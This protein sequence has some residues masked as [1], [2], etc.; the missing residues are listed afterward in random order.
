MVLTARLLWIHVF[1]GIAVWLS[2]YW[3]GLEY[4]VVALYLFVLARE[5]GSMRK[6]RPL[7]RLLISLAWQ[8]PA[9]F[10]VFTLLTGLNPMA[11]YDYAIFILGFWLTPILPC[12]ALLPPAALAH[13]LYYYGLIISPALLSLWIW[14]FARNKSAGAL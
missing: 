7:K 8:L 11:P 14:V 6:Y 9:Y 2:S 1:A 13:P 10:M 5:A 3:A 12:L 4:P